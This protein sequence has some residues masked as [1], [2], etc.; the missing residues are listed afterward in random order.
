MASKYMSRQKVELSILLDTTKINI[1][2]TS[3]SIIPKETYSSNMLIMESSD[4]IVANVT[5]NFN[6]KRG[7]ILSGSLSSKDTNVNINGKR[8]FA[9]VLGT[10]D[11]NTSITDSLGSFYFIMADIIGEHEVYVSTDTVDNNST[12]L[13]NKDIDLRTN[14]QLN[15]RFTIS[16]K[17]K[18]LALKLSQNLAIIDQ[19]YENN[20]TDNTPNSKYAFYY[21]ADEIIVLDEYIDLPKLHMYFSELPSSVRYN[22]YK[23]R[24]RLRVISDAEIKLFLNPL[25]MID[26]VA[27]N[28]VEGSS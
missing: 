8:I 3:I 21:K 11:V 6:E 19:F 17:E 22:P 24:D 14:Y 23:K 16:N 7:F 4:S 1:K 2:T 5:P 20:V 28:D 12:I 25:V 13:I 9:S 15:K 10:K 26:Y 27:V 18:A